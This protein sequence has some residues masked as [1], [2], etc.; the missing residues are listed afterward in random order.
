MN[1]MLSGLLLVGCTL[2]ALG[3]SADERYTFQ[4]YPAAAI[5]G[6]AVKAIDWKS[7]PGYFKDLK[8]K[9]AVSRT[10]GKT[11]EF[12]GHFVV[13]SFSCGTGCQ[14]TAFVDV[15]DGK[16]YKSPMQ[17]PSETTDL[18]KVANGK[19]Y[20]P[21][22]NLMFMSSLGYAGTDMTQSDG[23]VIWNE[24]AKQFQIIAKSKPYKMKF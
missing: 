11:A 15:N 22:S 20:L 6:K 9:D 3:A 1:K 7:N 18:P 19:A 23:V 5:A 4:A 13:T 16:I 21:S 8:S 12:A 10:V 2:G 24:Q 14:T 17:F